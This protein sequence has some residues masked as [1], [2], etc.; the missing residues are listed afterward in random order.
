MW[1]CGG[2]RLDLMAPVM[3][4]FMPSWW[5][6]H[7][8]IDFGERMFADV[9]H[10]ART[11]REMNRLAYDRFGNIGV[12]EPDPGLSYGVDDLGNATMPAAL[13]VEVVFYND[14]YAEPRPLSEGQIEALVGPVDVTQLYPISEV[15]R[16]GR[17]VR[18]RYGIDAKPVWNCHGVQNMCVQ[19]CGSGF[20]MD[21]YANPERARR[22]LGLAR[23]LQ[24]QSI[25]YFAGQDAFAGVIVGGRKV[26]YFC[27]LN[28]TIPL[29]GPRIYE[30]WLLAY[31]HDAASQ[32]ARY[33]RAYAIHHCGN[34]DMY[35]QM[36]SRVD[37]IV[38][39]EIGW[40][41]DL[42]KALDAFPNAWI[43]YIVRLPASVERNRG[44]CSRG[45][46]LA[47]ST[48]PVLISTG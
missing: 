43:Q 32:M 37:N 8:G 17:Y 12:G 39:L 48:R 3:F 31:E 1:W 26:E 15:I 35:A 38:W 30:D 5:H 18:E 10:R 6:R 4:N 22:L 45:N 28:C 40:G 20:F 36:Y 13:G 21:Y 29:S 24:R 27:G 46:G 16:Q 41:S 2:S 25:D 47:G 9:E 14:Q 42:R 33:G 19:I 23:D 7:Y 34:F 11:V 44:G